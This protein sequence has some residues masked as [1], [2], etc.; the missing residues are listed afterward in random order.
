[1]AA[2][3]A[4]P[5]VFLFLLDD[6]E[7]E[8]DGPPLSAARL[9]GLFCFWT[10]WPAAAACERPT[11]NQG[12]LHA[13]FSPIGIWVRRRLHLPLKPAWQSEGRQ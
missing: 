10:A 5:S 11:S 7:E 12:R 8:E 4:A 2:A 13:G 3:R 6:E 1:M 9:A